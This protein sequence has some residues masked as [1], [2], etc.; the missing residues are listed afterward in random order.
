MPDLRYS[1]SDKTGWPRIPNGDIRFRLVRVLHPLPHVSEG[2]PVL[3]EEKAA[4]NDW[5]FHKKIAFQQGKLWIILLATLQSLH[6]QNARP[7]GIL[8]VTMGDHR[9]PMP[10]RQCYDCYDSNKRP[11]SW[12]PSCC[13]IEG[14]DDAVGSTVVAR[15][16]G[17]AQRQLAVKLRK[18]CRWHRW[19]RKVHKF[20]K[21]LIENHCEHHF[22]G[23][24]NAYWIILMYVNWCILSVLHVPAH[25]LLKRSCPAVSQICVF[26]RFPSLKACWVPWH[27]W[28]I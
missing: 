24:I 2:L 18:K 23:Q 19:H 22:L 6:I 20:H 14:H 8:Q 1:F 9:W 10:L 5:T 12:A 3:M 15:C 26:A 17:P 16:N 13:D 21:E 27:R 11:L 7:D 4:T 28:Q 25:W